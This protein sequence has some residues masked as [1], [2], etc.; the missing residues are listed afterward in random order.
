[1]ISVGPVVPVVPVALTSFGAAPVEAVVAKIFFA[2]LESVV[3]PLAKPVLPVI[4]VG[5]VVP[6]IPVGPV[7]P[8]IPVG[9]VEVRQCF[10]LYILISS[11][12]SIVASGVARECMDEGTSSPF[13]ASCCS[14]IFAI[15]SPCSAIF[16]SKVAIFLSFQVSA[17][18]PLAE[19][20]LPVAAVIAEGLTGKV[21]PPVAA[22]IAEGLTGKVFPPVGPVVPVGTVALTSVGAAPVE[23]VVAKF[24]FAVL[25]SVVGPLAEPVLPVAAVIAE[26]L[27]GKVFAPVVLTS[28][29]AA[30]VEA[31]VAKLSPP[32]EPIV[33]VSPVALTSFL[34][35]PPV[36]PVGTVALTSVGAAPVEAV[37]AKL[38]PLFGPIS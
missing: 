4:P 12:S 2:V 19:P 8:V 13:S 3:G 7:V 37:V 10:F 18:G 1:V 20:V 6:V 11:L 16:F 35:A 31:V 15:A 30:P 9:P 34:G 22:V 21:F 17:V 5:P 24:F 28:F 14:V 32:F 36:E 29:G 27:T 26:G 33:P 38:S 25:E 23:A